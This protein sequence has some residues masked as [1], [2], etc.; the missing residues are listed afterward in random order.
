MTVCKD[1]ALVSRPIAPFSSRKRKSTKGMD[2]SVVEAKAI[3][4]RVY[5]TAV[6]A[7]YKLPAFKRE[8]LTRVLPLPDYPTDLLYWGALQCL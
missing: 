1:G 6:E 3:L 8:Y 4:L 5:R 2:V 7:R